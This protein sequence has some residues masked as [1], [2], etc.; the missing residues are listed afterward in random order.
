MCGRFTLAVEEKTI[1]DTMKIQTVNYEHSPRFN[2]APSQEVA[3]IISI[4]G[5]R[6][7]A[8]FQWG[9]LP[10]W[11]KTRQIGY[12]TF[13]ARSETLQSKPIFRSVFPQNRVIIVADG[14][15]EWSGDGKNKQPYRIR[16]KSSE[17]FGFAGLF[18]RWRSDQGDEIQS[19]TIIT[20]T[21][22]ELTGKIH[23]RMPVILSEEEMRIWL[24]S[25]IV[26]KELLQRLFK[27]YDSNDMYAYPVSKIV[28]N[29]R[30]HSSDLLDEISLDTK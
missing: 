20:T 12:N 17:V 2:I 16:V 15:Y 13:N 8:G 22:N 1:L 10:S 27:P 19:C 5:K 28:G 23:D 14:F 4:D 9:L 26:D 6:T 30:N 11:A 24:D 25:E 29:V 3:G 7:L 21:P 18:D